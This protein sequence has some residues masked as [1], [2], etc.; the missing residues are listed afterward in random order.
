MVGKYLPRA[1]NK[2]SVK[3]VVATLE[4]YLPLPQAK[5]TVAAKTFWSLYL[6]ITQSEHA[7]P[8]VPSALTNFPKPHS[9]QS[10]ATVK[11]AL[12]PCLPNGHFL[13]CPL[14]LKP[15]KED[16]LPLEHDLHDASKTFAT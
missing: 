2:Q 5:Q 12:R 14:E 16:H 9:L 11:P 4:V 1:H 13:H 3:D 15:D 8:D 10:V 6:P 7:A